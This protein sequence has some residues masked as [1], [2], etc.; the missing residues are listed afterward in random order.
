MALSENERTYDRLMAEGKRAEADAYA[1]AHGAQGAEEATPPAPR[2]EVIRNEWDGNGGFYVEVRDNESAF[3][4]T[5]TERRARDIA[6]RSVT[7]P[8]KVR[9]SR[10]EGRYLDHS[11]DKPRMVYRFKVSR[12]DPSYR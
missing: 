12:L 9:W 1:D 2:F 4:T 11:D 7:K 6:R 10:Q 3:A 8:E 5:K